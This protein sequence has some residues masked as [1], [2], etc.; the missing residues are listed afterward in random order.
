MSDFISTIALDAFI[1]ECAEN[2]KGYMER[3]YKIRLF[4]DED[5]KDLKDLQY[6]INTDKKPMYIGHYIEGEGIVHCGVELP[7]GMECGKR[8]VNGKCPQDG[9]HE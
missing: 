2:G 8:Y 5:V 7:N 3:K 6:I 1:K 9:S 4:K